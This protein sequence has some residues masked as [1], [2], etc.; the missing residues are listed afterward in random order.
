M[1]DESRRTSNWSA[2]KDSMAV[3][4]KDVAVGLALKLLPLLLESHNSVDCCC[5]YLQAAEDFAEL[6]FVVR[7]T[8]G[9]WRKKTNMVQI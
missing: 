1:N 8:P 4:W 7:K 3:S 5:C 2:R 9:C 6:C